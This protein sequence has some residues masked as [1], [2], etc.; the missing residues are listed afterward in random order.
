MEESLKNL[1]W[2]K[3]IWLNFVPNAGKWNILIKS[4]WTS[5]NDNNVKD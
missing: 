5:N 1:I 2:L 3:E 4:E